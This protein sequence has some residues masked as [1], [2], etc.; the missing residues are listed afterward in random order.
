[1]NK[2]SG[3]CL[4]RRSCLHVRVKQADKLTESNDD[5]DDDNNKFNNY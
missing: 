1:M 3:N 4:L 2:L 5:D